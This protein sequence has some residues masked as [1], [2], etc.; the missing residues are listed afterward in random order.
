[1]RLSPRQYAIAFVELASEASAHEL[2]A[3]T[4]RFVTL[5][6]R[7]RQRKLLPAITRMVATELN[8]RD[9]ITPVTVTTAKDADVAALREALGAHAE[10]TAN[11]DPSIIAGAV[12]E[13][14]DERIDA[15]IRSYLIQLRSTFTH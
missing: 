6:S 10:V 7:R 3:L 13:R 12:I 9:G 1:M 4:K 5:L 11:T 2:D 15:S 8:A 14:G